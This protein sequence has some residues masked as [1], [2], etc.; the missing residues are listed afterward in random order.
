[1]RSSRMKSRGAKVLTLALTSYFS[2]NTNL[3][4]SETN[5]LSIRIVD[6]K[7]RSGRDCLPFG[8]PFEVILVN[9]SNHPLKI[10]D[11]SCKPGHQ[12]LSFHT[13]TVKGETQSV[14]RPPVPEDVWTNLPAKT[15]E[16]AAGKSLS[17][18]VNFRDFFWGDVSWANA[19][20]PNTGEPVEISATLETKPTEQSQAEGVW[21]GHIES[22]KLKV[23]ILN[24]KLKTPQDYLWNGCPQQA[25]RLVQANPS[26]IN[27][28]E[29]EEQCTP[30]HH[31]ARFGYTN[32]VIW[33]V[34]HGADVNATAYNDF[35]PLHLAS[36]KEI[37]KILI[38]AGADLNKKDS[39]GKTPLQSASDEKH[40][41]VVEAILESGC[42]IDLFTAIHLKRREDAIKMLLH[43][44]SA[45]VGGGRQSDLWRNATPLGAAA[46]EGDIEL[47]KLLLAAGAPIDDR[48]ESP[49]MGGNTTPL[50][51]AVWAGK[52]NMV[53]F[54]IASGA[55][56]NAVGGKFYPS[57]TEYA[58]KHSGKRI[59][60]LLKSG[61]NNSSL[62]YWDDTPEIKNKLPEKIAK[63]E[64][65]LPDDLKNK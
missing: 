62:Q 26:L 36:Q 37:A 1:M 40:L 45:I 19:P 63:G 13:R 57:I 61:K 55:S 53:E 38:K 52:T 48:C 58:E 56:T 60:E 31:A 20:E 41:E 4:A 3:Y 51:N 43:D 2:L 27:S 35:T 33:L 11:V 9:H 44:S 6:S 10:W 16:I 59:V 54:L 5:D 25:L 24:P 47:A 21:I 15:L 12:T 29:P 7:D 14:E 39:W 65:Q 64:F 42:K 22:P 46:E 18:E 17:I 28:H 8:A 49:N 30:L 23:L 50:C 32:V 34:Q